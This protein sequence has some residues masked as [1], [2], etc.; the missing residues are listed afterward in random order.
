MPRCEPPR[1]CPGTPVLVTRKRGTSLYRVHSAVYRG[2]EF[3][4]EP[5]TN[6]RRGGRFDHTSRG[7]AFLY[8]GSTIGAAIAE[9]LMRDL[10]SEPTARY[11]P[12]GQLQGRAISRLRLRRE[13]T[14]VLLRGRGLSELGQDR[15][16]TTCEAVDYPSTRKW[17]AAIREWVPDAAG[18]AWLDRLQDR[19]AYIFYRSRVA[20]RD[21]EIVWTRR[22]DEG[23]GLQSVRYHLRKHRADVEPP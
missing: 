4:P 6:P 7:E 3:N 20:P 19:F 14:L 22:A 15:W 23:R 13:M 1:R 11:V 12:F 8:A 10:P 21:F 9:T 2:N 5:A 17:A 16:L 18:F